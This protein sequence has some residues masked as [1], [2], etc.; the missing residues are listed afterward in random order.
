LSVELSSVMKISGDWVTVT[1]LLYGAFHDFIREN[2][3]GI[4]MLLHFCRIQYP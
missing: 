3:L 1:L 4:F 2:E